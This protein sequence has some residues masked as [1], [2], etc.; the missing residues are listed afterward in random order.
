[1]LVFS[2]KLHITPEQMGEMFFY[3]IMMLYDRYKQ[4]VEEE[5][6][7]QENQ[8]KAYEEGYQQNM[9]PSDM[10]RSAQKNMP[11]YSN[12]NMGNLTKGF[13]GL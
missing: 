13:K 9:N 3:D 8:Q 5:N 11:N 4:Y 2:M 7:A 6:E 10:I 1:M 12:M